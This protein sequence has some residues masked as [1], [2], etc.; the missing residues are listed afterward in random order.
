MTTKEELWLKISNQFEELCNMPHAV[1]A[2]DR[3][4]IRTECP[5]LYGSLC[6]NYKGFFSKVLLAS[7]D[8]RWV[9]SLKIITWISLKENH[10]MK[11]LIYLVRKFFFLSQ[12][13]WGLFLGRMLMRNK[14][15][16][17]IVT[18]DHTGLL[19]MHLAFLQPDGGFS[20]S[21]FK[22]QLRM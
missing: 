2:L 19:K 22:Q 8:A 13:W 6:H 3:K 21:Q 17:T 7:C 9:N 5:K 20:K 12:S 11:Y 16:I 1:G 10:W 15:F 18:E 14:E 4:H